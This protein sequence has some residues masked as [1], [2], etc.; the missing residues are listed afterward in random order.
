MFSFVREIKFRVVY[1]PS[2]ISLTVSLLL[3]FYFLTLQHNVRYG[4]IMT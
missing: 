2:H 4:R 3:L 1:S